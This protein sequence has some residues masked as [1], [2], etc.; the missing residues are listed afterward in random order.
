MS[1]RNIR[2]SFFLFTKMSLFRSILCKNNCWFKNV[3]N[4][5]KQTH[6][7]TNIQKNILSNDVSVFLNIV[8]VRIN[9]S[10]SSLS[11]WAISFFASK[12]VVFSTV[13]SHSIINHKHL[14]SFKVPQSVGDTQT[15]SKG[16]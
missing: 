10:P 6:K 9:D 14:G 13:F 3:T 2:Y 11:I 8:I 1:S 15:Q 16:Y 12:C 4:I 7:H 5:Y